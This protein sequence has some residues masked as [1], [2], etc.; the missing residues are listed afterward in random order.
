MKFRTTL[1]L[2]GKTATG[3]CVPEKVVTSHPSA[4]RYFDGLSYSKKQDTCSRSKERRRP[5][6]ARGASLNQLRN[7]ARVA[8]AKPAIPSEY[9][10]APVRA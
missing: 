1:K 7:C 3:I 2:A 10:P 8:T 5:R 4:R 6:P 9:L